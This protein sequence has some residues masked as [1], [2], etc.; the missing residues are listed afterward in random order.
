M[1]VD[2]A[3][4]IVQ[5]AFRC[6]QARSTYYVELEFFSAATKIQNSWRCHISRMSYYLLLGIE[7]E[8]GDLTPP[9]SGRGEEVNS[10]TAQCEMDLIG[11]NSPFVAETQ[12]AA[13]TIQGNFRCFKARNT[14]YELLGSFS[15]PQSL[16]VSDDIGSAEP[17]LSAAMVPADEHFATPEDEIPPD[18]AVPIVKNSVNIS[19]AE[20]L[21]DSLNRAACTIQRSFRC[22]SG[23]IHARFILCCC[24]CFLVLCEQFI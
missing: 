12:A 3:A 15:L 9:D 13:I 6:F 10:S 23:D 19:Q 11:N 20:R 18:A 2:E 17:R 8:F 5:R 21:S 4:C 7:A 14:Y 16:D 22:F 24:A 1:M